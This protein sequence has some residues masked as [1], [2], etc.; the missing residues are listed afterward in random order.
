MRFEAVRYSL[1][2][3]VQRFEAV[4]CSM[5]SGVLCGLK[6]CSAVRF[7]AFCGTVYVR[8]RLLSD[9][10]RTCVTYYTP[11]GTICPGASGSCI[12]NRGR[13]GSRIWSAS[14]QRL[15]RRS[16]IGCFTLIPIVRS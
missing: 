12:V 15:L 6:P 14:L 11:V 4:R 10:Q 3:G 13:R 2:S 9:I 1:L 16:A 7:Q 5:L 8:C